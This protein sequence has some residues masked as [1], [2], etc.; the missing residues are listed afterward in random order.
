MMSDNLMKRGITPVDWCCSVG[1]VVRLRIFCCCTMTLCMHYGP[2][3][4]QC[5]GLS[6]QCRGLLWTLCRERYHLL[7]K[8]WMLRWFN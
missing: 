4:F 6:G 8:V 2:L 1:V 3:F 7:L 5:L